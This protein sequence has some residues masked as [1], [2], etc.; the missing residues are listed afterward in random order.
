MTRQEK[1]DL[2][3]LACFVVSLGV[4]VAIF[5]SAFVELPLNI[6]PWHQWLLLFFHFV[7]LFFLQ[8]L[9][10]HM[11]GPAWHRVLPLALFLVPAVL[12]ALCTGGMAL[13]WMLA[14]LWCLAPL[15]GCALGWLVWGISRLF[16]RRRT[17]E[18]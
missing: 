7:P 14:G 4:Y 5:A 9:M 13:G 11:P 2:F 8:L 17:P 10:C 1:T 16:C 18:P 3:L 12:F 6:R 15:L